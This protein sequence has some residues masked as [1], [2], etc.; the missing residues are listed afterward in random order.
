MKNFI[1]LQNERPELAKMLNEMSKEELLNHYALEVFEKE[2]LEEFKNTYDDY[3]TNLE[4]IVNA[5]K[6][7][8]DENKKNN[9][10][11][12]IS[13]EKIELIQK[14]IVVTKWI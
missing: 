3:H 2:E 10:Y 11:L 13:T 7:W 5:A 1:K 14:E 12:F 6:W 9:H 4:S 8:L